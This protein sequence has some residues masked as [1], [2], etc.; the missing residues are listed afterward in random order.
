[1][2]TSFSV[3][4]RLKHWREKKGLTQE[5]LARKANVSYNTIIKLETGGIKDPR[6][7]TITKLA[8]ALE[9]T[10]DELLSGE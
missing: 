1:M 2:S 5:A 7:S 8:Q 9:I 6:V 3:A 4:Q 10:I